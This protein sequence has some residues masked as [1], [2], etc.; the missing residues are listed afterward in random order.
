M[1]T[2]L[3]NSGWWGFSFHTFRENNP[4]R[5]RCHLVLDHVFIMESAKLEGKELPTFD[6]LPLAPLSHPGSVGS[7][8]QPQPWPRLL[9]KTAAVHIIPQLIARPRCLLVE[10]DREQKVCR[11]CR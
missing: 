4:A 6:G 10:V 5:T 3:K 1:T 7:H 8:V 2:A 9:M 11:R